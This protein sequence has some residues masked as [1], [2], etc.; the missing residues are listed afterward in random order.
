MAIPW[1]WRDIT[2]PPQESKTACNVDSH[3]GI[4]G[5]P[6][7]DLY[8][9]YVCI[10]NRADCNDTAKFAISQVDKRWGPFDYFCSPARGS[11]A[12]V[13][14]STSSPIALDH[15]GFINSNPGLF[16]LKPGAQFELASKD[17]G[18]QLFKGLEVAGGVHSE[19]VRNSG[20]YRDENWYELDVE[21]RDT[22]GWNIV[23]EVKVSS[24]QAVE[25]AKQY[26][27]Q[28]RPKEIATWRTVT[29]KQIRSNPPLGSDCPPNAV[30][31]WDVREY[32]S[33]ASRGGQTKVLYRQAF[34]DGAS[35]SACSFAGDG[36]AEF[37]GKRISS[38]L[39]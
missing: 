26:W 14:T 36:H 37:K 23:A 3:T 2:S 17:H 20:K 34:V 38:K 27:A 29:H 28:R 11:V 8:R 5:S 4:R 22:R 18:E 25:I 12:I 21:L 24:D 39:P 10:D 31:G 15:L 6:E 16:N 32:G 30:A 35:G 19:F 9:P 33:Y 13:D 7:P 1:L